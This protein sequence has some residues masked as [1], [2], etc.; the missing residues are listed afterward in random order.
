MPLKI[1]S[2]ARIMHSFQVQTHISTENSKFH[3]DDQSMN[4]QEKITLSTTHDSI[5]D[6]PHK[7][8][9]LSF[10]SIIRYS[11]NSICKERLRNYL[12]ISNTKST[13]NTTKEKSHL[14]TKCKHEPKPYA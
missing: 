6:P 5:V 4:K 1:S 2:Q 13:L 3:K 12:H 14:T 10:H 11:L 9:L 7:Y 8:S